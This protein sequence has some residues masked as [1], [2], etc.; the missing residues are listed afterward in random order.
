[1]SAVLRLAPGAN[2]AQGGAAGGGAA[3]LLTP[4]ERACLGGAFGGGLMR[5]VLDEVA[6]AAGVSVADILGPSRRARVVA[7]RQAVMAVLH[8]RGWS[9]P[10]IGRALRRDHS[11]VLHGIR[12]HAARFAGPEGSAS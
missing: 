3:P 9:S 11:T 6:A 8:R 2:A 1:M 10:R 5:R 12:A 7:A 4:A